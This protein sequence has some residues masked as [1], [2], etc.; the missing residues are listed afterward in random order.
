MLSLKRCCDTLFYGRCVKKKSCFY[1]LSHLSV[2]V[3][4]PCIKSMHAL[5]A[6]LFFMLCVMFLQYCFESLIYSQDSLPL[7]P[8]SYDSFKYLNGNRDSVS[9]CYDSAPLHD[10]ETFFQRYRRESELAVILRN[11]NLQL[12]QLLD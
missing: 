5:V 4:L 11:D 8:Y 10:S 3:L 9:L 6:T 1:K 2:L 7:Q 12:I